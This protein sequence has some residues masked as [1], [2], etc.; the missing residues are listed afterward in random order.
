M[1]WILEHCIL[2][3]LISVGIGAF[4][5]TPW[6]F[7]R[8]IAAFVIVNISAVLANSLLELTI[9]STNHRQTNLDVTDA[10]WKGFAMAVFWSLLLQPIY[11][12]TTF[13]VTG[14]VMG[15][16]DY[17]GSL[18]KTAVRNIGGRNSISLWN[19]MGVVYFLAILM[20]VCRVT[21]YTLPKIDASIFEGEWILDSSR[22]DLPLAGTA[23]EQSLSRTGSLRILDNS[24]SAKQFVLQFPTNF[25]KLG[26]FEVRKLSN[27]SVEFSRSEDSYVLIIEFEGSNVVT[28]IDPQ[29]GSSTP[30][31]RR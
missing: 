29:L 20:A 22:T 27:E 7:R 21:L 8:I 17:F 24:P 14:S 19:L 11:L 3:I 31:R 25:V 18:K 30:L 9:Q 26:R 28:L 23:L 13:V 10:L 16:I 5:P 12:A 15:V 1:N 2:A 6:R 4:G